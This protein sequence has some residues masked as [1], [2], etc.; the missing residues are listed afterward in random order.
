LSEAFLLAKK[1][2]NC[3]SHFVV[4]SIISVLLS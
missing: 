4:F 1:R 2:R 3:V